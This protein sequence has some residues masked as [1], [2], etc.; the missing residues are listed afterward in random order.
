VNV[1]VAVGQPVVGQGVGVNVCVGVFVTVNVG[2]IVGV[3]VIVG[4]GAFTTVTDPPLTAGVGSDAPF[5]PDSCTFCKFTA[6]TPLPFPCSVMVASR[7]PPLG[8]GGVF[9]SVLQTN[10]NNP[11]CGSGWKHVTVL[12][13]LPR[14][15]PTLAETTEETLGLVTRVNWNAP[16]PLIPAAIT[17]TVPFCPPKI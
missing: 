2:V 5:T 12:N 13:V 11:G 16:S 4:V 6:L 14:N 8:P 9:P 1:G 15:G 10:V 3:S 7:P 17:S